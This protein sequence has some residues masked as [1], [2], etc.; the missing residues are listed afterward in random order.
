[1]FQQKNGPQQIE[2]NCF[3]KEGKKLRMS[4][5][6]R[7][8][9]RPVRPAYGPVKVSWPPPPTF[10]VFLHFPLYIA[11]VRSP[12]KVGWVVRSPCTL[13]VWH[14]VYQIICCQCKMSSKYL[15]VR[16]SFF[17]QYVKHNGAINFQNGYHTKKT[18]IW[19]SYMLRKKE[20]GWDSSS[21]CSL[22]VASIRGKACAKSALN[23][24]E[25]ARWPTTR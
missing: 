9:A 16:S 13:Y 19:I 23:G 6:V 7:E 1:M 14:Y 10:P 15:Q 12:S 11:S 4:P 18:F 2:K 20:S 25:V 17:S 5:R 22:K 21:Y 3:T 24:R 8:A